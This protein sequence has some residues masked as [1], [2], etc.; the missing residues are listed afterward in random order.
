MPKTSMTVNLRNVPGTEAALGWASGHTVVI[1][2]PEGM[3]G[4]KGLGFNGGEL[5]ALAIGGCLCNDLRYVGYEMGID[6]A[7]LEVDVTVSL[8]GDPLRVTGAKVQVR[9]TGDDEADLAAL[10]ERAHEISAVAN[11]VRSGFPV[12]LGLA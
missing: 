3:A 5:I 7:N 8:D 1:D 6:I 9:L 10:F 2:R 12:T 4:G 11:S